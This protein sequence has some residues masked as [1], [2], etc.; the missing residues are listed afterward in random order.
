[1]AKEPSK[2]PVPTGRAQRSDII[3]ITTR[4][5]ATCG[6]IS[7]AAGEKIASIELKPGVSLNWLVDAVR[8]GVAGD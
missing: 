5:P 1:M 6:E 3:V 8:N 2:S 7:L 4:R